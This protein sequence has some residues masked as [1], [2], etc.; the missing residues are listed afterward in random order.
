MTV[1]RAHGLYPA[2][3]SDDE[4]VR[5]YAPLLDRVSRRVAARFGQPALAGD[6]WSVGAIGLIDAAR[7]FEPSR[8][9][10]FETFVEHRIRGAMLDEVRR[11]DNLPRR[12]RAESNRVASAHRQLRQTLGRAATS[13]EVATSLGATASE[14]R[15]LEVL[16]LPM[17]PLD[18][19]DG[20]DSAPSPEDNAHASERRAQLVAVLR[21]LPER[22]QVLLGLHYLECFTYREIA[23]VLK[24]SEPRICQLH[25]EALSLLRG[26]MTAEP[27]ASS[28]SPASV[29]P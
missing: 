23:E 6:L 25:A 16:A 13:E 24:V 14:V 8:G 17:V 27:L 1:H 22:L 15:E 12:M 11:M 18:D 20:P 10:R 29:S 5:Q 4:L 26:R 19:L 2:A 3:R 7:R 21:D 28:A 9:I